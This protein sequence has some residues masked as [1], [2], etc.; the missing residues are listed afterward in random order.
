MIYLAEVRKKILEQEGYPFCVPIIKSLRRLH[1]R[2]PITFFVGQNG[3][4]KS[5][6][7]EAMAAAIELP[8][9]GEKEVSADDTLQPARNLS[10][11]LTLSWKLRTHKGFFVRSEDFF[12]FNKFLTTQ[13][14]SLNKNIK[15]FQERFSGYGRLLAVGAMNAQAHA[16]NS[17][18]GSDLDANSHGETFL[19]VF[20]T[21]FVPGGLYLLD[22]PETPLSF[23]N[24]LALVMLIR[25]MVM[26]D[27]QFIIATH[28][29]VLA[30]IPEAEIFS[31]DSGKISSISYESVESFS[32]MKE[33]LNNPQ[34]FLSK[35]ELANL[36]PEK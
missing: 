10:S 24:Q 26:A 22:E 3:S 20:K 21:R 33:F 27:S 6:L 9:I 23:T 17:K 2:K 19:K 32:L 13:N 16:M 15:D 7:L 31:C 25:E 18:Y 12:G 29:P 8:V 30:A 11:E 14:S 34:I 28:S 4:G 5:T 1:F 36:K 35:I